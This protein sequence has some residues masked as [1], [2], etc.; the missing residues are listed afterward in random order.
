MYLDQGR[1][2]LLVCTSLLAWSS[3]FAQ[4]TEAYPVHVIST[5][6]AIQALDGSYL[7][8]PALEKKVTD[9]MARSCVTGLGIAIF[10]QNKIV[11]LNS[12]GWRQKEQRLPL[13]VDSVMYGASF[14]KAVFATMVTQLV[15]EGILDLDK[16]VEQYLPKPLPEYDKYRD[17]ANDL[18]YQRITLRMLLNHT[19]GF[20]NFRW[21]NPDKKLMLHFM[22]GSRYAYSGDG[23]NLAQFIVEQATKKSVGDLI[24]ERIFNPLQM[25]STSMTWQERFNENLAFGYDDK[26]KILG[27]NR[28]SNVNA[29][30][31]MDTTI[32]D[33]AQFIQ[34]LMQGKI[35]NQQ[36]KDILLKPG[37]AI[38]SV[39]QFPTLSSAT[40]QDNQTIQLSYGLGWG[41]FQTPYG[42]AYFKEGHDDGWENHALI[43]DD[44][45]IGIV[46]MSNS[47]NG[48]SIFKELLE[49]LIKDTYTP[50]KWEGYIPGSCVVGDGAK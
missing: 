12:F 1:L 23:I 16:P 37:I 29:A 2:I 45:Q 11:Y 44:K 9:L 50:W 4:T 34:S 10:N 8:V 42:K 40:T 41:L 33:F 7:P 3:S 18:R 15:Q 28:R 46:L 24:Q 27:H 19:A 6:H 26:E 35:L 38:N 22:P 20:A 14:T 30:G 25:V 43:Y 31:S 17:L 32:N 47:A 13:T 5:P 48:D 49:A 36:G 39:T 21:L